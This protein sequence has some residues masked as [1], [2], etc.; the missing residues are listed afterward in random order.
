MIIGNQP[1]VRYF[2]ALLDQAA[3]G[4]VYAF[5]GP[6]ELGKRTL[7][8]A[9]AGKLLGVSPPALVT[10]PDYYF[11]GRERDE[12]TEKLK[13]E[14]GVAQAR[15]L[16]DRLKG[17]AWQGGYQVIIIDEAERL[18]TEA[19]NALLKVL[20]EPPERTVIFLITESEAAL[21]PTVRSR[22]ELIYFS[23]VPDSE[24]ATGLTAAEASAE[25]MAALIGAAAGRPGR[26]FHLARDEGRA[27]AIPHDRA[28]WEELLTEPFY[29]KAKII[30]ELTSDALSERA[31]TRVEQA[32]DQWQL[33]WRQALL[34]RSSGSASNSNIPRIA[35]SVPELIAILS[36]VERA[37]QLV[38][39]NVNPRLVLEELVLKF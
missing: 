9:I 19:G 27:S 37:K 12:K 29:R 3:L 34:A 28:L 36:A 25:S 6:S 20:E 31:A 23:L 21:L 22:S 24:L 39:A 17:R 2:S 14:I 8:A 33:W 30:E 38:A 11:I 10:H 18:S 26:L 7:A 16:T 13:K 35:H 1:I 15:G 5:V 4:S 32:L